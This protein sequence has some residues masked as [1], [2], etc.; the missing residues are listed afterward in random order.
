MFRA[1]VT[2]FAGYW[3]PPAFTRL[4]VWLFFGLVR[5]QRRFGFVP[6]FSARQDHPERRD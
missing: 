6:R 2:V 3:R 1:L 5:A 4:R